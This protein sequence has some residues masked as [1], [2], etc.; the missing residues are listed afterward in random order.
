MASADPLL[1]ASSPTHLLPRT[2]GPPAPAGTAAASPSTARRALLDG[3]SRP[4]KGSK[5]LVEHARMVM[6]EC[7]NTGKLYHGD[8]AGVAA[9]ANGK[10]NQQGRRPVPDRKRFRFNTKP[11]KGNPV[12]NVDFSELLNIEDPDEYF[13]TLDLLEKADKEIKRLRGEAPIKATYTNQA[14]EPPKMRPGL[15]R[16]KSV[17]SY[18]FSA[19]IDTADAIEASASQTKT[20]TESQFTQDE[21][22][23]SASEMTKEPVSSRS[24]QHAIPDT[25]VRKDSFVGKE[26]RFTLNYLLSAF[27]DLDE[28]E[29]ENLL[30]ET[31]QIKEI[32]IGKVCLPDFTV[33]VNTP[34]RSTMV[35]KN[36]M[37]YHMLERTEPGSNLARISQLEKRIFV[38]DAL[39]DKHA[40]LSK[41]DE[42]D[43]SPESLLCK[44]SPVRHSS[45]SVVLTI[46]E[47]S[48]AIET[49]SPSIKSPEHVLE[50]EPNPPEGVTTDGRPMG[51]FPIGVD[52]HSELVKE[53]GASCRHSVPLE[54]DDMPI[55]YPVSSPHHLEG[56][57]TEVLENT[58]SRNVYPLHHADGNSEHQ[59]MVGGDMAQDNPI[60]TSEIPPEDTYPQNQSEICR[61]NVEKLAVDTRNALSSTKDKD[62]RGKNKKQPSK[63]GKRAT[64]NPIHTSEI[65]PED[66]YPQ[67]QSKIHRENTEKLA[68]D[69]SNA[70]SPSKGKE[71]GGESK[72]QTSK[73]G[74]RAAGEAGDLEIPAPN[75][76]P[77]NQPH[78]QDTDVEQQP[79][80]ISHSP[81]PSNGKRQN[82]VQKR[83]KKKD[84]NRRTSLADVGLTWQSGVRRSTRI[85]S[86][87]LQHWLGERFV[88]GRIHGTMATVIGVKS[89]SPSQEGKAA[90]RVK[91]FVPEQYSDLLAQSAKY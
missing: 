5:E 60:H 82:E 20:I 17:H 27:E 61:G 16:R 23:A 45:D 8:G 67:N 14:M 41:D 48:T 72:K 58:P 74:K 56:G 83:N 77:E 32:S 55:D 85:R 80:C 34:A 68:V 19:S 76:E 39:E 33:P 50:S 46:N 10:N 2:L 4:L 12:Q 35:Q 11:P 1:A 75:F 15:L 37:R 84:F 54:E 59:E 81:S 29:E 13:A 49:P 69:I 9:A 31:L 18:K 42:S 44:R 47:G 87:P 71:Q 40:D 26:N 65:L 24:G 91:S 64:D 66:T 73:R 86:R 30:R 3:I 28:T 7:G 52:R 89:F 38:G 22:H 6:K 90:M 70:L 57:S 25:S 51:S 53:K 21:V 63:R 79:A 78:V 88:Y 36:P 43:G 62:Q